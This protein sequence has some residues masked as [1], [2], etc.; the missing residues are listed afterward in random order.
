[1]SAKAP[2]P[3]PKGLIKPSPPPPPPSKRVISEDV[4]LGDIA[5]LIKKLTKKFSG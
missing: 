1:M 2:T 4:T 5:K 3:I